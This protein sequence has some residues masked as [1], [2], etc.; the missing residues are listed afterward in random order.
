LAALAMPRYPHPLGYTCIWR[1]PPPND[2][3]SQ[4]NPRL[5]ILRRSKEW[6]EQSIL[7]LSQ[8]EVPAPNPNGDDFI[9]EYD[10]TA[11]THQTFHI[12]LVDYSGEL[13]N[14]NDSELAKNLRQKFTEMDGIL[15]LAEAPFWDLALNYYGKQA[16]TDLYP[17]REAFSLLRGE[18]Q[19]GAALDVPVALLVTKWD[20][21][22]DID[23]ANP[24]NEQN[25]LEEFFNFNPPPP[26]KGLSDMLRFSVTKGNF[27]I[28][29]V[30]AL[31]ATEGVQLDNGKFVERPK[32]VTP[33]N[34]FGLEDAF[35]WV[36]QQRDA[37]DL[38]NYQEQATQNIKKAKKT[39]LA[40]LNRFPKGSEQ[41][42]Q[43][44]TVLQKC[45][46]A[47]NIRTIYTLIGIVA[48]WFMA[49]TT[50]DLVNYRQ[51][52]VTANNPHAT[53]EQLDKTEKWLSQYLAD[54]YF[55]HLISKFFFSREK[56]QTLLT[57]LQAHREKFLWVPVEKALEEN[58]FQ[59]AFTLAS[60]YV[61]YYPYGQHAQ[62]AQALKL[63]ADNL[64][65]Q[66]ELKETFRQ[67]AREM[68]EQ[69]ADKLRQL[70]KKLLKIQ[71]LQPEMRDEQ[72]RLEEEISK[73]LRK[74]ES[75]EE[76]ERF[77]KD[78]DQKM[79][80]GHF[81]AAA[82][83]FDNRQAD[84]RLNELK[85]TFKT[86][87]IQEIEQKVRQALKDENFNLADKLLKEY[88]EFPPEL[89]TPEAKI[90]VAALLRQVDKWQDRALY[91]AARQHRDV[92]HILRYLQ[93]APLQ[94]MA[95]EV[96]VYK[97]YLDTIAPKAILN[98]LQL[99]LVQIR[100]ENVD[101]YDNIVRVF[102]NGK[103]V[104]YNN[105]VD[106]KPNTST[107]FIGI[108][109]IFATQSDELISIEITVVNEDMFFDDDYGQ[110]TVKKPV[111]EL[112][113]GYAV[114]LRNSYKIK[115]GT[116]FFEIDGYPEAPVLPAWR[117]E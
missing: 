5:V 106:A 87:V 72:Q 11:S 14:P 63:R 117:G 103:Q 94:T 71:V 26:H 21:Y 34:A 68:Q 3:L 104:I 54:P 23:Y 80:A 37:I 75:Q 93:E 9:L 78:F 112:A 49:E 73:Q 28:F 77:R 100:W 109:P 115:T 38:Q 83:S 64:Q 24:A 61:K 56:A 50:L 107:G 42:K 46:K 110:G 8:Q 32:Q 52:K 91:E 17:L 101:D 105:K 102:L 2:G 59:A 98:Q 55:R 90:K 108:S 20:R 47:K 74:L 57:E 89:Q 82:Q 70:L 33:L 27:K 41:A 86:V 25:K 79:Q 114:A 48:L 44:N 62:K 35:I 1:E 30:S 60:E 13:I 51:H 65:Q 36:A 85:E 92:K 66:R 6:I 81:L 97:A 19:E 53:H 39:G 22:S 4:P 18:N 43:I 31:G 12:E 113:K 111:S 45:Q 58:N 96:S 40:L 15:V 116:A 69:N 67:I 29:P 99:K 16:Y 88:A 84:A 95:K 76:W 10:F 7:K